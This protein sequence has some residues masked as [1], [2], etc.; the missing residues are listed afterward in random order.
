MRPSTPTIRWP[1]CACTSRSKSSKCAT[2]PP[3]SW[4]TA[5]CTAPA[6]ITIEGEGE[7]RGG[8]IAP[9][10]ARS[11]GDHRQGLLRVDRYG[12]G[13]RFFPLGELDAQHPR[14]IRRHPA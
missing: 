12:S 7:G 3:T 11:I 9:P 10:P 5:T 6:T 4:S 2:P 14:F 8:G 13:L 1:A